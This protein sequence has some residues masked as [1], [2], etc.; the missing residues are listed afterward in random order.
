MKLP[1]FQTTMSIDI[2]VDNII[3]QALLKL[4]RYSLKA[5]FRVIWLLQS[6]HPP[7]VVFPEPYG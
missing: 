5:D 7:S 2:A 3:V 6:F 1:P 4:L